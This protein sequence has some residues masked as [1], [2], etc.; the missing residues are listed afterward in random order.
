MTALTHLYKLCADTPIRA[1]TS[2][3]DYPRSVT[4]LTASS[5]NSGVN[6]GVPWAVL[7]YVAAKRGETGLA[8]AMLNKVNQ[9][10]ATPPNPNKPDAISSAQVI[11]NELGFYRRI[12]N[13]MNGVAA[14]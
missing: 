1:A 3:T 13:I 12:Q 5:L 10:F 7:G 4:C 8:N 6:L 2:E 11:I 9:Q 14:Y